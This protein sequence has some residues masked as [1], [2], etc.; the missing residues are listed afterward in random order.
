M[1]QE[2]KKQ[3]YIFLTTLFRDFFRDH[4]GYIELRQFEVGH[5]T[6]APDCSFHKTVK[7][8][9]KSI[10][11]RKEV[12]FGVNPRSEKRGTKKSVSF[13]LALHADI[14]VGTLGHSKPS[15]H[16]DIRTAIEEYRTFK[17]YP[18][19]VVISGGGLHLYW[20]FDE[21][22]EIKTA[23]IRS[24]IEFLNKQLS[25]DLGGDTGHDISR[26]LR[27]PGTYN[28]KI[29]NAKRNVEI[30]EIHE[31]YK[32][33]LDDFE[34]Y[35]IKAI[36]TQESLHFSDSI[37]DVD[38]RNFD[39]SK[40][41]MNLVLFG[42][43]EG[44]PSRSERDHAAIGALIRAGATDDQI[45]GIFSKYPVGDKFMEKGY[46]G[47]NY[48]RASIE[49][50]RN[51]GNTVAETK[52]EKFNPD[53]FA[54]II[55]HENDL[56]YQHGPGFYEWL[57]KGVWRL[58][59]P[60]HVDA[61][62]YRYIDLPRSKYKNNETQM[63]LK[64]YPDVLIPQ[65]KEL[66]SFTNLIN[67]KNGMFDLEKYKLLKHDK[68]YF[69]TVQLDIIYTSDSQCPRWLQFLDEVEITEEEK[70]IVQEFTGYTLT[71]D[72]SQE[73]ALM[74]CGNGANGKSILAETVAMLIGKDNV[75]R[76]PPS[77]IGKDFHT[78]RLLGKL[79]NIAPDLDSAKL[80]QVGLL[81]SVISGEEVE[82]SFKHQNRFSFKPFAKHIFG[83]NRLPE[84]D[85]KS[86]GLYR[87]L[88]II[89]FPR[90]F[91]PEEQ[92]RN[93]KM[94]LEKE[95]NGIF[96]WALEGL[97]RLR[98]Q[99][100]FTHS[101]KV[102]EAV[103]DYRR[104]NNPL[105]YFIDERLTISPKY[106]AAKDLIYASYEYWAEKNGIPVLSKIAFFKGLRDELGNKID[107]KRS[108]KKTDAN[109]YIVGVSIK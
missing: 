88:I 14:D 29:K 57:D 98:K 94:K 4:E 48:L 85:D 20:L 3:S 87:R 104:R 10:D 24:R 40:K 31:E 35:D 100:S 15:K 59:T 11:M 19:I 81:K 77:D 92:D 95:L 107:D 37:V 51:D 28:R 44:Y 99:G 32:Y 47:D 63:A 109:R 33:S 25:T 60:D 89:E 42:G 97:K 93:L 26:I 61:L 75:S 5:K 36:D 7:Q 23:E 45:K 43:H 54:E 62:V 13:A 74:F 53:R 55:L 73:K 76:V 58:M 90:K 69:S 41:F 71:P 22:V 80:R 101:D 78:I 34:E 72:V 84:A 86:E 46:S 49:K 79:L 2:F 106:K 30:H 18:S 50:L 102:I 108:R 64:C 70:K 65:D 91:L 39:V 27:V 66:N 1:E 83:T 105:L 16:Q 9:V 67:L 8:A 96:N 56:I 68:K 52:K 17:Y 6:N 21:P 103:E 82:D 12:C 38:I